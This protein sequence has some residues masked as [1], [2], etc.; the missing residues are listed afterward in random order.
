[1]GCRWRIQFQY[2][3]YQYV[4]IPCC[5]LIITAKEEQQALHIVECHSQIHTHAPTLNQII[6]VV[7]NIHALQ[8]QLTHCNILT[9]RPCFKIRIEQVIA[10]RL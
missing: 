2:I 6:P 1:M 8:S 4:Q 9:N 5:W 3:P 10:G 7:R